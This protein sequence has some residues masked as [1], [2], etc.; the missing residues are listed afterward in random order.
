MLLGKGT[1]TSL[2]TFWHLKV[3]ITSFNHRSRRLVSSGEE[4]ESQR[5][6]GTFFAQDNTV[7]VRVGI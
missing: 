4:T 2:D 7:G 3:I 6:L 5:G 1:N